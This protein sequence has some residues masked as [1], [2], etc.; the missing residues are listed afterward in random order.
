MALPA[1]F[2]EAPFLIAGFTR[3]QALLDGHTLGEARLSLNSRSLSFFLKFRVQEKLRS[4]SLLNLESIFHG[5]GTCFQK[6]IHNK[7][8]EIKCQL[9]TS[10][11]S[12]ITDV[13]VWFCLPLFQKRSPQKSD[14]PSKELVSHSRRIFQRQHLHSKARKW[15][16]RTQSFLI[17]CR[18]ETVLYDAGNA[19][20]AGNNNEKSISQKKGKS[21]E[22]SVMFEIVSRVL[23]EPSGGIL[24]RSLAWGDV[25][26][27]RR[28]APVPLAL[29]S[30]HKAEGHSISIIKNPADPVRQASTCIWIGPNSL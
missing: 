12:S 1:F 10:C 19:Y 25:R 11:F 7:N 6:G 3:P 21:E 24:Q 2:P 22:G 30:G 16:G 27:G 18:M 4:S 5:R 8:S 17:S 20:F 15:V 13:N 9:E 29:S 23:A 14:F 28:R 26:G